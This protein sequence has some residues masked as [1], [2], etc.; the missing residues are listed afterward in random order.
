MKKLYLFLGMVLVYSFVAVAMN[1]K[2]SKEKL[3]GK[4]EVRIVD[5]PYGYQNYV[6]DIKEDKGTYKMDILVVDSHTKI[7]NKELANKEGKMTANLHLEGEDVEVTIWE[8]K[9]TVKGIAAGASIGKLSAKF[10]RAK[11]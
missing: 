7:S 1:N 8:E 6:V 2:V 9:G 5:A 10:N 4:W 11:E 3:K